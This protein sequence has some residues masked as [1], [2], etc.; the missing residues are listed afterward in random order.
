[1]FAILALAI[2][3]SPEKSEIAPSVP[4]MIAAAQKLA[5]V[6]TLEE[7]TAAMATLQ[8]SIGK[9]SNA[10]L[11]WEKT[12]TLAPVMKKAIPALSTEIKRLTRSEKTFTR[13]SNAEKVRGASAALAVAALGCRPNVGETRAPNEKELWEKYCQQLY[14][15]SLNLNTV[16]HQTMDGKASFDALSKAFEAVD[17]TCNTTCHEKFG[18][19]TN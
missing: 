9:A 18:G 14:N 11:T 5:Q 17:E 6:K 13:G 12:V 16:V 8:N 2:G 1:M 10:P 19:A 15:T 7:T 4:G 3:M